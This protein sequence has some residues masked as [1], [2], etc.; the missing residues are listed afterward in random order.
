MPLADCVS[1]QFQAVIFDM[2]L[3][4]GEI[5]LTSARVEIVFASLK[6]LTAIL[7]EGQ[8]HRQ[9]AGLIGY[10]RRQRQ[11]L[12]AFVFELGKVLMRGAAEIDP[13]FEIYQLLG[14]AIIF[15]VGDRDAL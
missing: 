2:A 6:I 11:K 4:A 13:L 15:W 12:V 14:R 3:L 1:A 9:S 8:I 5:E 10:V 7:R